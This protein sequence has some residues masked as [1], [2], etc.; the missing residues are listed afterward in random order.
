MTEPVLADWERKHLD[1]TVR[2]EF[3][4]RHQHLIIN[5][6]EVAAIQAG[7]PE[8]RAHFQHVADEAKRLP[9]EACP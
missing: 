2:D 7:T 1:T 6:L 8:L 3:F 5:A 4:A 9:C